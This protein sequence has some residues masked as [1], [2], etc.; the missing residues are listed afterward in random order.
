MERNKGIS[1]II[2]VITIIVIIILAGTVML[3]LSKNN[4]ITSATEATFKNNISTYNSELSLYI[5]SEIARNNGSYNTD[6][7]HAITPIEI[8]S[9]IKS[10]SD[11]DSTKFKII[12][13]KLAVASTANTSEISWASQIGI[14]IQ[15][16]V[17]GDLLIHIDGYDPPQN[18][19]GTYYWMDKSEY[20]ND[21]Q[22]FNFANPLS[23]T[24][25]GY[26]INTKS[27]VFDGID[28]YMLS[29]SNIPSTKNEYTLEIIFKPTIYKYVTIGTD[30]LH[31]KW[32]ISGQEPY[33]NYLDTLN[34]PNSTSFRTIPNINSIYNFSTTFQ[35]SVSKLYINSQEYNSVNQNFTIRSLLKL[36]V[37]VGGEKIQGNIYAIRLYNRVLTQQELNYNY[38]LD[39]T[40]FGII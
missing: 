38:T 5:A 13:G 33:I 37:G 8:K 10:M 12:N 19:A 22:M 39:A 40:R 25:S 23:S 36:M 34:N 20:K 11:A 21:V 24:T 29:V 27:Y 15:D 6:T 3:S 7:L 31:L 26:D 1:L 18:I 32:R 2:L 17:K 28:D 9:I 30:A 14:N 35:G 4:P 16:Y